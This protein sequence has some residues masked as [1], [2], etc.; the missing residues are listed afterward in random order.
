[1]AHSEMRALLLPWADAEVGEDSAL[2]SWLLE[3]TE[4]ARELGKLPPRPLRPM[5]S[6][7]GLSRPASAACFS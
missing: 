4:L 3:A 7:E 2:D 1:M 6:C 5:P